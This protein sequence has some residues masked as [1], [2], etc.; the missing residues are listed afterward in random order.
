MQI[1]HVKLNLHNY[2]D[3]NYFMHYN[4]KIINIVPYKHNY[5]NKIK[6]MYYYI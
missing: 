6:F 2:M 5:I 1:Q 4:M 3:L